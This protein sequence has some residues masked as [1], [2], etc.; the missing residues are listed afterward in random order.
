[1]EELGNVQF[2]VQEFANLC[3][4]ETK[5]QIQEVELQLG[6]QIVSEIQSTIRKFSVKNFTQSLK[7]VYDRELLTREEQL[8]SKEQENQQLVLSLQQLEE[9][10][11]SIAIR[12]ESEIAQLRL[13]IEQLRQ[14]HEPPRDFQGLGMKSTQ[15]AQTQ[16]QEEA[17]VE[18]KT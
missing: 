8:I 16:Q 10:S 2:K 3:H 13:T 14:S 15:Q 17:A 5:S 9:Q 7:D 11:K 6:Q 4:C 18:L 1:M 12:S